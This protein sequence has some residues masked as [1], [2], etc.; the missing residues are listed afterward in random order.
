[1][2]CLPFRSEHVPS[3]EQVHE[4]LCKRTIYES[5]YAGHR[6]YCDPHLCRALSHKCIC[7]VFKYSG[8]RSVSYDVK[9]D[10]NNCKAFNHLCICNEYDEKECKTE[11]H[12]CTC[13]KAEPVYC[14]AMRGTHECICSFSWK[15]RECKIHNQ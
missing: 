8:G 6:V 1:M 4:C 3:T 12:E 2:G 15:R 7:K 13:R 11:I 10:P 5:G 9:C 14:R